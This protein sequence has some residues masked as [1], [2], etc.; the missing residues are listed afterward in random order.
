MINLIGYYSYLFNRL[1][2]ILSQHHSLLS[3]SQYVKQQSYE[4]IILNLTTLTLFI[5]LSLQFLQ[6]YSTL[7]ITSHHF[8][9]LIHKLVTQIISTPIVLHN[10]ST[11][12]GYQTYQQHNNHQSY[13]QGTFLFNSGDQ[14][15]LF[16][17]NNSSN[18][19][20][21]SSYLYTHHHTSFLLSLG[22]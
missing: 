20:S 5:S 1:A 15:R 11:K 14:G 19:F 2:H 9:I 8:I 7:S 10:T 3:R 16:M 18:L 13:I 4:T 12:F 22:S 21:S 17:E 6:T